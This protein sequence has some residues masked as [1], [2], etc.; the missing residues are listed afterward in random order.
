M[1]SKF[2]LT[3][4][5][6]IVTGSATGIGKSIALTF[7]E[8]GAHVVVTGINVYDPSKSME[9][10]EVVASKIRNMGRKA[11]SIVTDVRVNEQVTKM[12]E[13]SRLEFG[14]IDIL[15]NNVGGT[16]YAPFMKITEGGW[17]AVLRTN[18]KSV[19]LCSQA[20][21]K[22]MIEQKKG[23]IVNISSAVGL[24]SSANQPH[25][26]AAKAAV[27][28][29]THSLAVGLA[30]YNIR[31]NSIAPGPIM[32]EGAIFLIKSQKDLLDRTIPKIAMGRFGQPEEIANTAVFLASDASSYIT[33]QVIQVDGGIK[34]FDDV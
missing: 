26:A 2:E 18:L 21:G 9:D 27:I 25:Y 34:G 10:L 16:F 30:S 23:N 7:A 22:I 6:A 19:F 15:V 24:S 28:N 33:G 32:T 8:A 13:I 3:D 1:S 29:L 12:T 14:R 20:V 5:V 31:V 11:L 4:R 17:D